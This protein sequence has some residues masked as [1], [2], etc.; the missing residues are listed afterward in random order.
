H[1]ILQNL[2]EITSQVLNNQNI[3]KKK[4]MFEKAETNNKRK[5]FKYNL[6]NRQKRAI[7]NKDESIKVQNLG[8]PFFTFTS[9]I[10][11]YNEFT[12]REDIG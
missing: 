5:C 8:V 11:I 2:V 7:F 9:N 3:S 12:K 6:N 10:E 4:N 1:K